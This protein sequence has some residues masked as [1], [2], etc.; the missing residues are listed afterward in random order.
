M[1]EIISEQNWGLSGVGDM[2]RGGDGVK[3]E[4]IARSQAQNTSLTSYL[5]VIG[6]EKEVRGLMFEIN[7]TTRI[8]FKDLD[9]LKWHI[10]SLSN[11]EK[12]CKDE[13]KQ[14]QKKTSSD[15]SSYTSIRSKNQWVKNWFL[16]LKKSFF[17]KPPKEFPKTKVKTH[18]TLGHSSQTCCC[19]I[20]NLPGPNCR[21]TISCLQLHFLVPLAG[22][23]TGLLCVICN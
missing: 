17:L 21:V 1:T 6:G 19:I 14:K 16:P 13:K 3:P 12:A 9:F 10:L 7:I 15:F 22:F 8:V 5:Y 23:A 20:W 4:K 11:H 2:P 18:F